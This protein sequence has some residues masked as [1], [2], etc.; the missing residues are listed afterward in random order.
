MALVER[1]LI[2]SSHR[3]EDV[4][5]YVIQPEF[6]EDE[7]LEYELRIRSEPGVGNRR[8]LSAKL[9][10]LI[11]KEQTGEVEVPLTGYSVPSQEL[12]HCEQQIPILKN[13]LKLVDNERATQQRYMTKHLHLEGR[14]NRIPKAN[15]THDVSGAVFSSNEKLSEMYNEF[16]A[17]LLAFK[18]TKKTVDPEDEPN[19]LSMAAGGVNDFATN[20]SRGEQKGSGSPIIV[21]M[22][23]V[24]ENDKIGKKQFEKKNANKGEAPQY[25]FPYETYNPDLFVN[26]Q[27]NVPNT[28]DRMYELP[29]GKLS[30]HFRHDGKSFTHIPLSGR[31]SL[32]QHPPMSSSQIN[33]NDYQNAHENF[34]LNRI[35]SMPQFQQHPIGN[36][37]PIRNNPIQQNTVGN[38]D[39]NRNNP[40]PQFQQIPVGNIVPNR[41]NPTPQYEQSPIERA[42]LELAR[43]VQSID[44]RMAT[45]E[46][47]VNSIEIR[48][49]TFTVPNNG[50]GGPT[51]PPPTGSSFHA[52]ENGNLPPSEPRTENNR[53]NAFRRVPI[54]KWGF[55]FT[56]NS[57]SVIPEE[58][59][60][61]AF[62]RRLEI[63]K[64]AEDVT[65]GE[66]FQ[67]FHYLLKGSALVWYTQYQRE[68]LQWND[69]K[70]GFL[71][72]YT[73][74]LSKFVVAAKLASRRQEKNESAT[75]YISSVLRD[76]DEMEVHD[77]EERISIVQNG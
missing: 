69:L 12:R 8:E 54:H 14:L 23:D 6:L 66:I 42:V 9:R 65:Y 7:E 56:A 43:A 24:E 38:A 17:K 45:F 46:S 71:R 61:R 30:G 70:E 76:F 10:N 28:F 27:L 36:I 40:T 29:K 26:E 52:N 44:D 53:E 34:G 3:I 60:A 16:V 21:E 50:R 73:T 77:E 57:N 2:G 13:I 32:S 58:R 64:N 59:D 25:W 55:Y 1:T 11:K 68:F 49:Q 48:N 5:E 51:V 35:N 31:Q 19:L 37:G 62:L 75:D 15:T 4:D 72:Q 22:E 74:P 63:F 33:E 39:P 20:A 47:R 67:K 18:K 41:N